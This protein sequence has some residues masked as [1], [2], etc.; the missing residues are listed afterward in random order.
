MDQ[1]LGMKKPTSCGIIV[2]VKDKYLICRSTFSKDRKGREVWGFPKGKINQGETEEEAALRET[3]EETGLIFKR[4]DI[5]F[6]HKYS[7]N[8]K[9]FVFFVA[10]K[11]KIDLT[12]LHCSTNVEGRNYP[13]NDKFLLVKK[14]DL[15]KYIFNHMTQIVE[16]LI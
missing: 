14:E 5:V 4:E 1:F 3:K 10:K 8:K 13:E 9:N 12:K 11:D 15:G 6:F 2:K 7:T 16:K